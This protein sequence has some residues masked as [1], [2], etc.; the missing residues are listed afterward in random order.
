MRT[1][2]GRGPF[3]GFYWCFFGVFGGVSVG[4]F[5]TFFGFWGLLGI[6]GCFLGNFF[7]FWFGVVRVVWF[8]F[9]GLFKLGL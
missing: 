8:T 4:I 6:S 3:V 2:P 9:L 1:F 5:V 7:G